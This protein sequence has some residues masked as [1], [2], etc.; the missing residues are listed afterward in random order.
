MVIFSFAINLLMLTTPL[1]M[2]QVIDR[3]LPSANRPTLFF[4]V[5]IALIA[6]ATMAIL[7]YARA[8]I[9]TRAAQHLDRTWT[10]QTLNAVIWH[11]EPG[12]DPQRDLSRITGFIGSAPVRALIDAP[13]TPLF[14][15]IAFLLH[16]LIGWL[17]VFGAVS[18]FTLTVIGER[19]NRVRQSEAG[20]VEREAAGVAE[21]MRREHTMLRGMGLGTN[22]RAL[23]EGLQQRAHSAMAMSSESQSVIANCSRFLRMGIQIGALAIGAHLV[24]EGRLTGGGM[25]ASSIILARGLAPVEQIIGSWRMLIDFRDAYARLRGLLSNET[26]QD[27]HQVALPEP[28][29]A[30]TARNLTLPAG[31]GLPPRLN[32]VSFDV[33]PGVCLGVLGPS[34]SGKS[35]LG[36]ILAG[37]NT[38]P[39]GE[40]RLDGTRL[41][42]WPEHQRARFVAFLP[43]DVTLFPGTVA[44]NI[45]R[46]AP[47]AQD[48][49][50]VDAAKRAGAHELI[51]GLEAG[52]NTVLGLG[53]SP[54][55]GGE[56]QRLALA[57]AL[58]GRPKLLILDEP[59]AFL[60][61]QGEEALIHAIRGM[62]ADGGAVVLI[63]HRA[64]VL[65]A[66]DR[67][68][69]LERGAVTDYGPK[70]DVIA[71]MSLRRRTLTV[72]AHGEKASEIR[73]W[74]DTHFSGSLDQNVVIQAE[75]LLIEML[76]I[77]VRDRVRTAGSAPITFQFERGDC[78]LTFTMDSLSGALSES[79][80]NDAGS[81]FDTVTPGLDDLSDDMVSLS[82][83]HRIAS[84]IG[85]Q[86]TAHGVRL[87]VQ[88]STA[89]ETQA[90]AP[91][92][93]QAQ[94]SKP[95]RTDTPSPSAPEPKKAVNA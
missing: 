62:K 13:F 66:A 77:A 84:R 82:L 40:V 51:T 79:H 14:I 63:A 3:V 65:T 91:A 24:L 92:P 28:K 42:H 88:M 5:L 75:I 7:E 46:H 68:M 53:G 25:V 81:I 37:I 36:A 22:L 31:G 72:D 30:L 29:A 64:G 8:A 76:N 44:Q 78:T 94:S 85:Q 34:G 74:L 50:V 57:R 19:L 26:D 1:F 6:L 27:T 86:T 83:I 67:L 95:S 89:T 55:S 48:T 2:M 20:A 11:A 87:L 56:R 15:G 18:L 16:P 21:T 23:H 39:I 58:Y 71:R 59:N 52:Y 90:E 80:L 45:A 9:Q 61:Q 38:A 93:E 60:D 10:P 35:T 33:E 47:D 4:L 69:L 41:E 49:D 12:D 54:L 32:R 17:S 73:E 43:Q 70:A